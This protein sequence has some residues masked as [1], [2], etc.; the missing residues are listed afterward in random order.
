LYSNEFPL[1]KSKFT[2]GDWSEV[3]KTN[4][5]RGNVLLSLFA[6]ISIFICLIQV[7]VDSFN[8]VYYG[9]LMDCIILLIVASTYL[10]NLKGKHLLAKV[11]F[12]LTL[13][14]I[15]FIYAN[16]VPK[17]TGTY[18]YFFPV[19]GMASLIFDNK[20]PLLKNTLIILP[21]VCVFILELT[22]YQAF[23]AINIQEGIDDPYSFPIN[24]F[25]SIILTSLGIL[26]MMVI[27]RKIDV[28][29]LQITDELKHR[30]TDLQKTNTELD[31]FVYSTSHDLKAP[32]SSISGLINIAKLEVKEEKALEYF[33][34]IDGRIDKLNAFIKDIIDLSRNARLDVVRNEVDVAELIDSVIENN[35]YIKDAESINFIKSVPA[36]HRFPMDKARV[37][38]LLNNLISNAIKYHK[39]EGD[40]WIK[41]SILKVVK[42]L[43]FEIE[44]NG[45]GIDNS[46]QGKI[47]NMFYRGHEE[48]EGSGLGLYIVSD[49]VSKLKGDISLTSELDRG[50]KITVVIPTA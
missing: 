17:E 5:Q 33:G 14:V 8:G 49:V 12:I 22:N 2:L 37:E 3:D 13:N 6:I 50:T 20:N 46:Q 47:F 39:H 40:R 42:G 31:H 32:L 10:L 4:E 44:D 21:I 16:I 25:I 41:I 24:L 11:L 15:A 1:N 7:I 38:V 26:Q 34:M 9:V 27:N 35:R 28:K 30:N 19:I 23:G 45:I 18:F 43:R 29:R 36:K 48:S